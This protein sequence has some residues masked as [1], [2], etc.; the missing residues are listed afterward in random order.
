MSI[1]VIALIDSITLPFIDSVP[2]IEVMR[3]MSCAIDTVFGS[4]VEKVRIASC[5]APETLGS[6]IAGNGDFGFSLMVLPGYVQAT[7]AP[8]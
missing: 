2:K 7:T 8:T 3:P 5:A 4:T 1:P 6:T